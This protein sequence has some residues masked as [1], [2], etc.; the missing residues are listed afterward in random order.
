MQDLIKL[1]FELSIKDLKKGVNFEDNVMQTIMLLNDLDKIINIL[2]KRLSEWF[3]LYEPEYVR[4]FNF[5]EEHF[6][7]LDEFKKNIDLSVGAKINPEE[8]KQINNLSKLLL[9]IKNQRLDLINYL[10]GI[11]NVNC[12]NLTYIT[13]ATIA[14]NLILLAKGLRNLSKF[15][16]STVQLLGAEKALFKHIKTGAKSPK[17]GVIINHPLISSAPRN[18][19]GK[20]ARSLAD[21]ISICAKLDYFKGEFLAPNY[22]HQLEEKYAKKPVQ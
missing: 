22:L 11:M 19:K 16:A 10:E 7:D 8:N 18:M 4:Q 17:H 9:D 13:N 1:N 3:Y 14:G 20:I 12:P 21:K 5:P 2:R 6:K 15:P